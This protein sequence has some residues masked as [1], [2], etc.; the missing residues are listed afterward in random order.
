M[1]RGFGLTV[2]S[3]M[4]TSPVYWVPSPVYD[5]ERKP[6]SPLRAAKSIS[7]STTFVSSS[8]QRGIVQLRG[9]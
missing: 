6:G 3:G 5:S 9:A 1:I 8:R 7:M 4:P 2:I